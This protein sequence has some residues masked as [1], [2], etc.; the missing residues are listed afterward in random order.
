MIY[1]ARKNIRVLVAVRPPLLRSGVTSALDESSQFNVVG[2]GAEVFHE[3]GGL[4]RT[5]RPDVIVVDHVSIADKLSWALLSITLPM[6]ELVCLL[7]KD[8]SQTLIPALVA[9]ARSVLDS[10]CERNEL[11]LA[12]RSAAEGRFYWC[13]R[14]LQLAKDEILAFGKLADDSGL[15]QS[16]PRHIKAAVGDQSIVGLTERESEV[17][18]GL[19]RGLTNGQIALRLGLS[20]ATIAFHAT[21]TFRELGVKSRTEAAIVYWL[22]RSTG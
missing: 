10:D 3:L 22:N 17:L 7:E 2:S 21:R 19:A 5:E 18:A 1:E 16:L 6:A 4:P 12:V 8:K 11:L 14:A 20:T 13:R 9:K 15:L